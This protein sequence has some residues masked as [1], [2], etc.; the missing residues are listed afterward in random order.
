MAEGQYAAYLFHVPV[1]VLIQFAVLGLDL[2][3]F[4]KFLFVTAVGVML[5]FLVA[6]WIRRPALLRKIL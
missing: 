4:A 2:P 6:N 5:T 3:P 1:I